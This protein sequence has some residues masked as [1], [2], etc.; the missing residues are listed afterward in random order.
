MLKTTNPLHPIPATALLVC[1]RKTRGR[2]SWN[3][4]MAV[5]EVENVVPRPPPK[6]VSSYRP[7]RQYP[8]FDQKHIYYSY[9]LSFFRVSYLDWRI[10]VSRKIIWVMGGAFV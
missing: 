5:R 3:A 4:A 2:V 8:F 6:L 9:P 10:G 7:S 1:E